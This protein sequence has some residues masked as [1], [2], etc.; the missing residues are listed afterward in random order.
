MR[1][2][3]P[4]TPG[5]HIADSR[6][7]DR[8]RTWPFALSWAWR[9]AAAAAADD[10]W[11]VNS[12]I[13]MEDAIN[14]ANGVSERQ[15]VRQKYDEVRRMYSNLKADAMAVED[16]VQ[17]LAKQLIPTM[18][19][20]MDG[21]SYADVVK[22]AFELAETYIAQAISRE[23]DLSEKVEQSVPHDLF[24]EYTTIA[25]RQLQQK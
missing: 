6:Y 23:A 21:A 1:Q 5:D 10:E 2:D 25:K 20:R 22:E 13:A 24:D 17:G 11:L 18:F 14:D 9:K 3:K 12:T 7:A 19:A 15:A 16:A 4:A 8:I